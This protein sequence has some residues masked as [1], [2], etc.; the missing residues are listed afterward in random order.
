MSNERV[1]LAGT[2][3]ARA[4]E[5][6]LGVA[7][8]GN[9]QIA[10]LFQITEGPHTGKHIQ[11]Y[12]SFA[13]G[14]LD[15]TLESLRHCGW[16][17]DSLAELDTLS[18]NEIELVIAD[19]EYTTDQGEVKVTSKV[20]WV[21]RRSRLMLKNQMNAAQKAAFAAKMRGKAI[22]SKQK[23]GAQPAPTAGAAA[24]PRTNGQAQRSY[25]D[26]YA[27]EHEQAEDNIPF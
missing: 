15:R 1:S 9:E 2:W 3:P 21:N 25:D 19:E 27:P 26:G 4:K 17:S 24:A 12:L 5:W 7:K 16:D 14:A 11:A 6:D 23:Y 20:S 10:I 8:S 13:G 22:A 18:N